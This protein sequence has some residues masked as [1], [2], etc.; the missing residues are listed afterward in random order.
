[1]REVINQTCK[2]IGHFL[3]IENLPVAV[4]FGLTTNEL[5]LFDSERVEFI[6]KGKLR[7][8]IVMNQP[9]TGRN[10]QNETTGSLR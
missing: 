10:E 4:D 8:L 7:D 3:R 5:L 9:L 2:A 6:A 1:M